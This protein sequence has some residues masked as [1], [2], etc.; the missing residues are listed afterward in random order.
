VVAE[1]IIT[2]SIT[3]VCLS[4]GTVFLQNQVDGSGLG[5]S[6]FELMATNE[7]KTITMVY[8]TNGYAAGAH[9]TGIQGWFSPNGAANGTARLISTVIQ[10]VTA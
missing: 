8:K 7:E 5:P 10:I 3:V 1:F 9:T 4:A 6:W 2:S